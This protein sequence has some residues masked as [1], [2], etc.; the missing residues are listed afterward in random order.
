V[1]YGGRLT[2]PIVYIDDRRL[3]GGDELTYLA[4]F[5]P[6]EFYLVEVFGGSEVRAYTHDFVER[7]ALRQARGPHAL[8]PTLECAFGR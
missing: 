7:Q 3:C 4:G 5:H 6:G 2:R 8:A 1:L